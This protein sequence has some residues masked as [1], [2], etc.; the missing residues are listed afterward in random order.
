MQYTRTEQ[1]ATLLLTDLMATW[2]GLLGLLLG[3]VFILLFVD[4]RSKNLIFKLQ[5]L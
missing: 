4:T 5:V 2:G 3:N 1:I